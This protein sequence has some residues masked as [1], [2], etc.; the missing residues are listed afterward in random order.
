MVENE[1][2]CTQNSDGDSKYFQA[3]LYVNEPIASLLNPVW[4]EITGA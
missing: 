2:G 4:V 1:A 3:L